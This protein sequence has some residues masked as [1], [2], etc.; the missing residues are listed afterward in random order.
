MELPEFIFK[1]LPDTRVVVREGRV[2]RTASAP[3][4]PYRGH[5]PQLTS[6]DHVRILSSIPKLL[7]FNVLC[8]YV[9]LMS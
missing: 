9:F 6:R 7:D 2:S 3:R 4:R 8:Q 5:M 1:K